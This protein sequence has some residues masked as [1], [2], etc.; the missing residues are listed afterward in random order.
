MQIYDIYTFVTLAVL[1]VL[2]GGMLLLFNSK[3]YILLLPIVFMILIGVVVRFIHNSLFDGYLYGFSG[4]IS[5]IPIVIAFIVLYVY[6]T[7]SSPF[8]NTIGYYCM[9]LYN[10]LFSA[11]KSDGG[12]KLGIEQLDVMDNFDSRMFPK[13]MLGNFDNKISFDWLLTT[14][15]KED[16]DQFLKQFKVKDENLDIEKPIITDFYMKM[17]ES[18]E[19]MN[20]IKDKLVYLTGL[21]RVLGGGACVIIATA[22]GVGMSIFSAVPLV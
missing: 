7:L 14:I 19:K 3:K 17:P 1:L 13:D 2:A 16:V 8:D 10:S 22:I 12:I 6:P 4:L 21:K 5:L 18:E 9:S 20:E 15:E 11:S